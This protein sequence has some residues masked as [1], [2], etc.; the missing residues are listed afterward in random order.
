NFN[1][2]VFISRIQDSGAGAVAKQRD[3]L[4][5]PSH[6]DCVLSI[7]RDPRVTDPTSAVRERHAFDVA[8]P[9]IIDHGALRV[10]PT[11]ALSTEARQPRGY[12]NRSERFAQ[13]S[14]D[15]LHLLVA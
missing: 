4:S 15:A 8:Q 5:A 3:P 12:G 6:I 14:N 7:H 13:P 9:R 11:L 1:A 2:K 10:V